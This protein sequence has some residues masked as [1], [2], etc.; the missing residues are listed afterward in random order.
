ML[1]HPSK[2]GFGKILLFKITTSSHPLIVL[3]PVDAAVDEGDV[4][5]AAESADGESTCIDDETQDTDSDDD[6]GS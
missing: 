1:H 5:E 3:Q 4:E 2:H 6:F